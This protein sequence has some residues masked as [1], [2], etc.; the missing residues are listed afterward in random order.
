MGRVFQGEEEGLILEQSFEQ[1]C[2]FPAPLPPVSPCHFLDV[3]YLFILLVSFGCLEIVAH[4]QAVVDRAWREFVFSKG[5]SRTSAVPATSIPYH[6]FSPFFFFPPTFCIS[7]KKE[8]DVRIEAFEDDSEAEGS[9]G[10]MDIKELRA[11]KQ[12]LARKVAEQQR[13][14]D[15]IQV[16]RAVRLQR[17]SW[18][19]S[20]FDFE[21]GLTLPHRA[22]GAQP[23]PCHASGPAASRDVP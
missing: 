15:K 22:D 4:Q 6:D 14:Q 23:F 12:A 13:R 7:R 5:E 11:K 17:P 18:L 3:D 19:R 10:E 1:G 9:G 21:H 16:R 2:P 20:C 8:D